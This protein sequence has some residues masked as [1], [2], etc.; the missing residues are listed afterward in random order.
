MSSQNTETDDQVYIT[1]EGLETLK[2]ELDDLRSTRRT[3]VA[4]LIQKAK[5]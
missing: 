4:E 2:V 5:F 1:A 3:E